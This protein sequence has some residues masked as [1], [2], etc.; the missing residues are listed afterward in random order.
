[1]QCYLVGL[2]LY[3]LTIHKND[4]KKI[5][6]FENNVLKKQIIYEIIEIYHML[7]IRKKKSMS[8]LSHHFIAIM[9]STLISK[10]GRK[11]HANIF[12][13]VLLNQIVGVFGFNLQIFLK[14]SKYA[15]IQNTST[16]LQ[17]LFLRLPIVFIALYKW[18]ILRYKKNHI[19]NIGN[20][21]GFLQLY[22]E[23]LWIEKLIK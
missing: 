21:L 5:D 22:N 6:S 11:E 4:T 9:I 19:K 14:N 20:I 8:S 10:S 2:N 3:T 17:C 23:Y 15:N 1:M 12:N 13:F 7:F 18:N 16:L